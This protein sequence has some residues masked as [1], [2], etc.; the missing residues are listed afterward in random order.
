MYGGILRDLERP[1]VH[2][3]DPHQN[4]AR[5]RA[6]GGEPF[7]WPIN[8][9]KDGIAP[10][11]GIIE[12]DWSPY[13]FT[14]NWLFTRPNQRVHF[15]AD[16]PFC[17]LFP[18]PRGALEALSPMLRKLSDNPELAREHAAWSASRIDFNADLKKPESQAAK[19]QWQKAYFRGKTHFGQPGPEGHRSKLRLKPFK[20]ASG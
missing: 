10:L 2:R 14:M 6:A 12:T 16:E 3:G 19:E 5:S 18:V 9:P 8:R 13:T 20:P 1:Q 7:R 15:E 17:H 11:S 4:E